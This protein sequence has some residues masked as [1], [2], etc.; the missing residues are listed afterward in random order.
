MESGN[1]AGASSGAWLNW[2][3]LQPPCDGAWPPGQKPEAKCEIFHNGAKK[4]SQKKIAS[5]RAAGFTYFYRI[6]SAVR[7]L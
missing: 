7:E 3:V 5:G 1:V 4:S 2:R 6:L